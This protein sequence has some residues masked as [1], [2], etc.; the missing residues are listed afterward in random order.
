MKLTQKSR[1]DRRFQDK[2]YFFWLRL[3]RYFLTFI[4]K[5][6]FSDAHNAANTLNV[7]LYYFFD[8]SK[9]EHEIKVFTQTFAYLLE[10]SSLYLE[11]KPYAYFVS[12]DTLHE[13]WLYALDHEKTHQLLAFYQK[14]RV[15]NKN[16]ERFLHQWLK[17]LSSVGLERMDV[18]QE[19]VQISP[20]VRKR[21][22]NTLGLVDG[23]DMEI[24]LHPW[25]L[26]SNLLVSGM[27]K[28]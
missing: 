7:L 12:D 9:L 3:K 6:S 14:L 16:P 11:G 27:L 24:E 20:K 28:R 25:C 8:E 23:I 17:Y 10:P 15:V 26:G 4:Q 2:L 21:Y 19:T 22:D 5:R 13:S 18:Q 1:V